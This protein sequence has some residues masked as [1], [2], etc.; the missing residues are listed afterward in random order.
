[1]TSCQL[2]GKRCHRI[3]TPFRLQ[4]PQSQS[5]I[6]C[7]C[8]RNIP[9]QNRNLWNRLHAVAVQGGEPGEG[10]VTKMIEEQTAKLPSDIFLLAAGGAMAGSLLF[11]FLGDH[12]K[13]TFVGQWVPT[14]LILGLYNKLVKVWG[15]E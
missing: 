5:E 15:S 14:L 12:K 1:M 11:Q 4:F 10:T 3:S 13:S 2:P 9:W 7:Q 8:E 6:S